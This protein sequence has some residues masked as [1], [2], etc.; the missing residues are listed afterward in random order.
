MEGDAVTGLIDWGDCS[1]TWL[2]AEVGWHAVLK[3]AICRATCWTVM[4]RSA[5]F[6]SAQSSLWRHAGCRS[7]LLCHGAY[8]GWTAPRGS[9]CAAG[10]DLL[11]CR[12]LFGERHR[13]VQW[14]GLGFNEV[15]LHDAKVQSTETVNVRCCGLVSWLFSCLQAGYRSEMELDQV[16]LRLLPT[17]VACRIAQSL[18]IGVATAAQVW[19]AQSIAPSV[20]GP[21]R[22]PADAVVLLVASCLQDPA[23]TAY[24]TSSHA[25]HW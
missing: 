2:V 14:P 19:W 10:E 16:E 5:V 11:R 12:Q 7:A 20:C 13:L 9:R 6:S 21:S 15:C 25:A 8:R 17:L 23:N 18:L 22:F 24:L 4:S 1:Y 3:P